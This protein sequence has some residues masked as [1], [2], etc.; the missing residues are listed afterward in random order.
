[1]LETTCW[2]SSD[3]RKKEDADVG[4]MDNLQRFVLAM[5]VANIFPGILQ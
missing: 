4:E 1:M 5:S 2:R 3:W